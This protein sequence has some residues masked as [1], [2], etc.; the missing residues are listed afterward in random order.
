[1]FLDSQWGSTKRDQ[2]RSRAQAHPRQQFQRLECF[3]K[4]YL[5]QEFDKRA[6]GIWLCPWGQPA[7]GV[8]SVCEAMQLLPAKLGRWGGNVWRARRSLPPRPSGD[9]PIPCSGARMEHP[10]WLDP[11]CFSH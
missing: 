4:L 6:L 2:E 5:R 3:G 7:T 1:G 8:E 10:V 9:V 11:A